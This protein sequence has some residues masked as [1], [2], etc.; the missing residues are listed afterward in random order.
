MALAFNLTIM[1]VFWLFMA[2]DIFGILTWSGM[3]LVRR[4]HYTDTHTVPFMTSMYCL[5]T[6]RNF[7]LFP[8][9]W[10]IIWVSCMVYIFFNWL[11][12]IVEGEPLYPSSYTDWS[13]PLLSMATYSFFAV[14]NA[15]VF[16]AFAKCWDSFRR[17]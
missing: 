8:E 13:N 14:L 15:V 2:K 9:D 7:K 6:T 16:Y 12:G 3:D 1:P 11:G 17:V 10:K 5:F 4:I